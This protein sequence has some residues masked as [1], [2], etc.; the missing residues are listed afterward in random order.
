MKKL[1]LFIGISIVLVSCSKMLFNSN[2]NQAN[3]VYMLRE[4]ASPANNYYA[5]D[6]VMR[7]SRVEP[8]GD[9][10]NL[11]THII[12]TDNS[13]LTGAAN[14]ANINNWCSLTVNGVTINDYTVREVIEDSNVPTVY[15]LVLD[16]SGSM[17]T[18]VT[19][20]QN[21]VRAFINKKKPQDAICIVKYD[22][23]AGLEVPINTYAG[24]LQT[25]FRSDGLGLY[26]GTTAIL[27]GIMLGMETIKPSAYR[28]KV[29]ISFTDGA[30]NSS[31]I[32]KEYVT[33]YAQQNNINL[34]TIDFNNSPNNNFM[35]ELANNT[36]GTYTYFSN[37]NQFN[38]VFDD[39]V[40][41]MNHA[42]VVTYKRQTA[43]QQN[44]YLR[45]CA[46]PVALEAHADFTTER[47]SAQPVRNV[48]APIVSPDVAS[49][50]RPVYTRPVADYP[51]NSP[52]RPVTTNGRGNMANP[53]ANGQTPSTGRGP[54][55]TGTNNSTTKPEPTNT[56][57]SNGA[58]TTP[59]KPW[60]GGGS[61]TTKPEPT[62]TGGSSGAG[63][64]TVGGS[65][66]GD[67]K[68]DTTT[69]PAAAKPVK[70]STKGTTTG[71]TTTQPASN[72]GGKK[73]TGGEGNQKTPTG[74]KMDAPKTG[75]P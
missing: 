52:T 64:S 11:Y 44:V 71:G 75:R 42:Y 8:V 6:P 7:I 54:G 62:K 61:S 38:N 45:Y 32:T 10:V 17:S 39:I 73:T 53:P 24:Q 68:K 28:R 47:P 2:N 30:D 19:S 33:W 4:K 49:A 27:N 29:V 18:R 74:N 15:A 22:S 69:K 37:T 57:G 9:N 43:G 50:D 25:E 5:V 67:T 70:G 46:E 48:P 40:N 65:T 36:G 3:N 72:T 26:G 21:A 13:F 41:K 23:R 60:T 12:D 58:T 1:F 56:G 35:P 31:T 16:H 20:M 14:P 55:S 51:V 59:T 66:K 34:C 63:S